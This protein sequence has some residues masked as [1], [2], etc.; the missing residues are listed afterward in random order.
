VRTA[1][2]RIKDAQNEFKMAIEFKK[3]TALENRRI[4]VDEGLMNTKIV[5]N[6]N[7]PKNSCN[8]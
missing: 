1:Y 2:Q 3:S 4:F 5:K 6:I 8:R 7:I